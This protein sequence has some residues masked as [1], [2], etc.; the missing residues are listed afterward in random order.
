[1]STGLNQFEGDEVVIVSSRKIASFEM[2]QHAR[3]SIIN[4]LLAEALRDVPNP[5][6]IE[7]AA[8][9]FDPKPHPEQ[10]DPGERTTQQVPDP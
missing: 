4:Q 1:M 2:L 10:E 6:F 9:R 8:V 7:V 3:L 5:D